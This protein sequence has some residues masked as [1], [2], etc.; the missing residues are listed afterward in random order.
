[1]NT[2]FSQVGIRVKRLKTPIV[3]LVKIKTVNYSTIL[4]QLQFKSKR[5]SFLNEIK[6]NSLEPLTWNYYMVPLHLY[7][8]PQTTNFKTS[9]DAFGFNCVR[10]RDNT[11]SNA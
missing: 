3:L 6:T 10:E 9:G 4:L 1:M 8:I 7:I 11:M 5:P 2:L